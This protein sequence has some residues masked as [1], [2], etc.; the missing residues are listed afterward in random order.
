MPLNP[1]ASCGGRSIP[2]GEA[3]Y[4]SIDLD[5]L[6][7]EDARTDWDQGGM[8]LDEL[9]SAVGEIARTCRV[10]GVDVCGGISRA[11]GAVDED[12]TINLRTCQRIQDFLL[13]LP[14]NSNL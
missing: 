1:T 7:R 12:L 4:L 13:H 14:N 5:V 11:K 8:T 10:L 9:L 2:E 6:R 3:V